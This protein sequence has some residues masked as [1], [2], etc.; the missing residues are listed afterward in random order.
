MLSPSSLCTCTESDLENGH[1]CLAQDASEKSAHG[2]I[3]TDKDAD[4]RCETATKQAQN[5]AVG[6]AI[7]CQCTRSWR[8]DD[9]NVVPAPGE[10]I[11]EHIVSEVIEIPESRVME[12]SVEVVRLIPKESI[13][14]RSFE[15]NVPGAAVDRRGIVDVPVPQ[16]KERVQQFSA[17]EI[18]D[19][20]V[21]QVAEEIVQGHLEP[22]R[23]V[24]LQSIDVP[25]HQ[26]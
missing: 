14:Q 12:E 5:C 4:R 19:V 20:P 21:S 9:R 15:E 3:P 17:E 2:H 24:G 23:S 10:G 11:Q 1:R 16:V 18:V 13:Q 22:L 7:M 25:V 8:R 26:I 6:T